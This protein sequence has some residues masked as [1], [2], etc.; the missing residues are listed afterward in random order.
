MDS[1]LGECLSSFHARRD[2]VFNQFVHAII[3]VCDYCIYLSVCPF[4]F[5]LLFVLYFAD[6]S[7]E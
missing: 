7:V 4:F 6:C 3:N 5:F 2:A 1:R